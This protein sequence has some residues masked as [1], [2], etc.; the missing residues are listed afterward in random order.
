LNFLGWKS[1]K[2]RIAELSQR[3]KGAGQIIRDRDMELRAAQATTLGLQERVTYLERCI[4]DERRHVAELARHRE[5]MYADRRQLLVDLIE[6]LR[7]T[8]RL[9]LAG[10]SDESPLDVRSDVLDIDRDVRVL[11]SLHYTILTVTSTAEPGVLCLEGGTF[12]Y[13]ITIP[14]T[15]SSTDNKNLKEFL[16]SLVPELNDDER[17][18][19]A[20]VG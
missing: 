3:F 19:E 16:D 8:P 2:D 7:V 11:D 13:A 15:P 20:I 12:G 14:R 5:E 9:R 1:K 6:L 10:T 4:E 18:D 17:E